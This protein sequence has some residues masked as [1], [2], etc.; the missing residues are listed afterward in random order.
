MF[1]FPETSDI[2]QRF[3]AGERSVLEKVY[4]A[5]VG[6]VEAYVRRS[7]GVMHGYGMATADVGDLVQEAF[8]RAFA[9][10]ARQSFDGER[11]FGPY[12][13]ALTRNLLIDWA[14]RRG[15]ELLTED[16]DRVP[17][18]PP[19][20]RCEWADQETMAVVNAYLAELPPDLREVHE[21]RYVESRSQ[22]ETCTALAISRQTLRTR[23][24]HLR[25]GLRRRLKRMVVQHEP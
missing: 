5:Y 9:D 12:L 13:G 8:I 20:Q 18:I 17:D 22:D 24:K 2:L 4:F 14:R 11:D 25:D 15:R 10:K 16:L 21:F 6:E 23:E 3:K 19:S 7:L 1:K